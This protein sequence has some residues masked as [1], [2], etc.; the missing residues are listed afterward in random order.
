MFILNCF[1]CEDTMTLSRE[2]WFALDPKRDDYYCNECQDTMEMRVNGWSS[3]YEYDDWA[4][5][6]AGWGMDEDY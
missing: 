5:A 2:D 1:L 6:S 3:G 4:L